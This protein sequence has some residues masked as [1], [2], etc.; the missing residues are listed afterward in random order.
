MSSRDAIELIVNG[1]LIMVIVGILSVA[2][3]GCIVS[4]GMKKGGKRK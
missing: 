3:R 4:I 2:I 1:V